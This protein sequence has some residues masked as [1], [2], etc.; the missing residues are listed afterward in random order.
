MILGSVGVSRG[1]HY[2]EFFVDQ[3]ENN[4]DPAF[5]I[6]RFDVEKGIMLGKSA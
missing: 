6:A 2:W 3:F 4:C 5:G 1:L